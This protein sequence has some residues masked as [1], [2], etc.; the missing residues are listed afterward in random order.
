MTPRR[1]TYHP[2]MIARFLDFFNTRRSI[3]TILKMYMK[4]ASETLCKS[5]LKKSSLFEK[6]Y[7]FKAHFGMSST[8]VNELWRLLSTH[9]HG[10][11]SIRPLHVLWALYFLKCYHKTEVAS[12]FVGVSRKTYMTWVWRVIDLIVKLKP[13]VVS[14]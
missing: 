5:L 8:A 3:L 13:H 6:E 7:T 9:T 12:N 2:F 10:L 4:I 14:Q 1:H 11:S